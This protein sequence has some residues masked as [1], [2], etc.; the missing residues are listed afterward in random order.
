MNSLGFMLNF[1]YLLFSVQY[2]LVIILN[3]QLII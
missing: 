1:V 3:N 2:L